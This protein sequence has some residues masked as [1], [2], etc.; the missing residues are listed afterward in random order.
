M[1]IYTGLQDITNVHYTVDINTG[2]YDITMYALLDYGQ[3]HWPFP[4][5]SVHLFLIGR[6][7]FLTGVECENFLLQE[8]VNS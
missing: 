6:S 5:V 3:W 8:P 2:L 1:D 7:E 4:Q